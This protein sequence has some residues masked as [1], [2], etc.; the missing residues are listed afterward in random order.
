MDFYSGNIVR[1]AKPNHGR[2]FVLGP[3]VLQSS[4]LKRHLQKATNSHSQFTLQEFY[5][6]I[7]E[8]C[9]SKQNHCS[10]KIAAL[11]I[12][13]SLCSQI[14]LGPRLFLWGRKWWH[15]GWCRCKWYSLKP[16]GKYS[17]L[18]SGTCDFT[19]V[20]QLLRV[21]LPIWGTQVRSLAWDDATCH[22]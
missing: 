9:T 14:T 5:L 20:V 13:V 17:A 7:G 11:I 1:A 4:H 18:K 12:F 3:C 15:W 16:L 10:T 22:W 8:N 19:L 21:L 2:C 6:Y